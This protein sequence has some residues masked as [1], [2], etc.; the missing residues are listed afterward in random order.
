M[1][2]IQATAT[3]SPPAA[4]T[5]CLPSK[6]ARGGYCWELK[7]RGLLLDA[8]D[9]LLNHDSRNPLDFPVTKMARSLT[10]PAS[11]PRAASSSSVFE[12]ASGG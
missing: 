3:R 2:E 8:S 12:S 10:V 7:S 1:G 4:T 5:I 9:R 11:K 6:L